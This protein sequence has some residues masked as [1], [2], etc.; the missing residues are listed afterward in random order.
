M[1]A[2]ATA[3]ETR[4]GKPLTDTYLPLTYERGWVTFR[5]RER[6]HA[7][8]GPPPRGDADR[9]DGAAG[10]ARDG[11]E[12]RLTPRPVRTWP[13]NERQRRPSTSVVAPLP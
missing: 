12:G 5:A 13:R 11:P 10:G 9:D 6:P 2:Y 1:K 8:A 3:Y 4:N 7:I